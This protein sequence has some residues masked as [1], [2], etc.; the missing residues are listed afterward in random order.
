VLGAGWSID[1][2]TTRIEPTSS[3]Q[4]MA[5]VEIYLT[6]VVDGVPTTKF[7]VGAMVNKDPDMAIK[8]ALAEAIKKAGHQLGI[9]LY[10]WDADGRKRAERRMQLDKNRDSEA[11][12]KKAVFDLAK[13]R[14]G[15]ASPTG[16]QVAAAFGRKPGELADKAVL[17]E[18][19]ESAGVL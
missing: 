5:T 10:L 3:G 15:N 1:R 19:L 18:I 13:E 16:A 4:Y 17:V 12:L 2:A 11:T 6:A 9:A 8:T 7:G 14:L